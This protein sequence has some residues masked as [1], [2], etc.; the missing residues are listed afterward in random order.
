MEI[1]TCVWQ[2]QIYQLSNAS[3]YQTLSRS[4]KDP[5]QTLNWAM[6]KLILTTP[7]RT[8]LLVPIQIKGTH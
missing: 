1:F 8:Q 5:L 7:I 3:L 2:H 6:G 4:F